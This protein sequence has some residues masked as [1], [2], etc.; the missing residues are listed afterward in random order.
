MDQQ[1]AIESAP[2]NGHAKE[3]A[4]E[5]PANPQSSSSTPRIPS[6]E[7]LSARA[8]SGRMGS[9][10]CPQPWR[11]A[12]PLTWIKDPALSRAC[13]APHFPS[14]TRIGEILP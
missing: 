6:V 12:Q 13:D 4:A 9:G 2:K 3:V 10:G 8:K 1:Y 14:R 11:Q 5:R 7:T